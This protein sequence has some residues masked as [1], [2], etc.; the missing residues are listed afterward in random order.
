VFWFVVR[1]RGQQ[2]APKMTLPKRAKHGKTEPK[3]NSREKWKRDVL[4][5]KKRV[6]RLRAVRAFFIRCKRFQEKSMQ[7][8]NEGYIKVK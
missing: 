7:V 4:K 8:R 3:P 1:G 2:Q 5:N 6:K